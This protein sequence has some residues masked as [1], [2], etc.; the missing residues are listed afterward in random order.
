VMNPRICLVQIKSRAV[1]A[2]ALSSASHED[3]ATVF[4]LDVFHIPL[5]ESLYSRIE[6]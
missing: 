3:M 1:R 4:C 6:R 2:R 5:R